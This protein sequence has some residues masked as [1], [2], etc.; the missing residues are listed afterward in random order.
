MFQLQCYS[1]SSM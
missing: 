1:K